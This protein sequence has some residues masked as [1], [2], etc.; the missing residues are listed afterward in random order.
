MYMTM[1][2]NKC[3]EIVSEEGGRD[4]FL[5]ILQAMFPQQKVYKYSTGWIESAEFICK[6]RGDNGDVIIRWFQE[7]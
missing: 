4:R 2:Y 7:Q 3:L 5:G 1:D 6:V